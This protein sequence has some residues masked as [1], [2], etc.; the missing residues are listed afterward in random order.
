MQDIQEELECQQANHDQAKIYF[1][2]LN[3]ECKFSR[4]GCHYC[5]EEI[6][7]SHLQDC[8]MIKFIQQLLD[9][10]K[11]K[12]KKFNERVNELYQ[13]INKLGKKIIDQIDQ[14]INLLKE[15]D[16]SKVED[17][18]NLTLNIYD[19]SIIENRKS[20]FKIAVGQC[21]QQ[22]WIEFDNIYSQDS[23]QFQIELCKNQSVFL[24]K[25]N[26]YEEAKVKLNEAQKISPNDFAQRSLDL[27]QNFK[28]HDW[29][30][31]SPVEM[32]QQMIQSQ[33]HL[34]NKTRFSWVNEQKSTNFIHRIINIMQHKTVKE[35]N[36]A[37]KL[38]IIFYQESSQYDDQDIQ[39]NL[40]FTF[41]LA[42]YSQQDQGIKFYEKKLQQSSNCHLINLCKTI[43]LVTKNPEQK[44]AI[45]QSNKESL[46][47]FMISICPK[48]NG[49]E[50]HYLQNLIQ[51]FIK[52]L[53]ERI[54]KLRKNPL[55]D[56]YFS[57]YL[58]NQFSEVDCYDL[59]QQINIEQQDFY[60][61]YLLCKILII[62]IGINLLE[63]FKFNDLKQQ[64]NIAI[65]LFPHKTAFYFFQAY[66]LIL[67]EQ[68]E[69]VLD[70]IDLEQQK[71]KQKD[72]QFLKGFILYKKKKYEESLKLFEQLQD[73]YN[74]EYYQQMQ[75]I[76]SF[77]LG[78]REQALEIFKNIYTRNPK[79]QQA[80]YNQCVTL[81]HLNELE[82]AIECL[83]QVQNNQKSY[84]LKAYH[85]ILQGNFK[86]AENQLKN[87]DMHHQKQGQ[88]LYAISLSE[89]N[90]FNQ[91][92][93]IINMIIQNNEYDK[94]F[95][96]HGLN[97][98][99]NGYLQE[100]KNFFGKM[101]ENG[102]E[103]ETSYLFLSYILL[104]LKQYDELKESLEE[105]FRLNPRQQGGVIELQEYLQQENDDEL[106]RQIQD[107]IKKELVKISQDCLQDG[108]I[109]VLNFDDDFGEIMIHLIKFKWIRDLYTMC[110]Q[111][112]MLEEQK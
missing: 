8:F 96:K 82:V 80:L 14:Y 9:N 97:L 79:N 112:G 85:N 10:E 58:K 53:T 19:K 20:I 91:A 30:I 84:L 27:I 86:E 72:L 108:L 22:L 95:I 50:Q 4:K 94:L 49:Y 69:G 102:M 48:E 26:K 101:I 41:L 70:V 71:T 3:K 74:F 46:N 21:E 12:L 15:N 45:L 75:G 87:L 32:L 76:L 62:F 28:E 93:Q 34:F 98:I 103:Q 6:H 1:F 100:A 104:D 88:C 106:V 43:L 40:E 39:I 109:S 90:Q 68:Y 7:K 36:E 35:I 59:K 38:S 111:F 57:I 77:Y 51:D 33:Q 61:S 2:C 55:V 24:L 78:Q 16:L 37:L 29:N 47:Q 13:E 11:S 17:I 60:I 107:K 66:C 99:N 110:I 54:Y 67:E 42:L 83:N 31:V 5:A 89:S 64:S 44:T 81:F 105:L 65:K 73:Q 92:D 23:K 52:I 25:H 18:I 56:L 63:Q